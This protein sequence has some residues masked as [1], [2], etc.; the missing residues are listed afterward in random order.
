MKLWK[1]SQTE[2]EGYDTYSDAVVAAES[3]DDARKIHPGGY[4]DDS[5]FRDLVWCNPNFVKVEF[6]GEAKNGTQEGVICA[7]FHAG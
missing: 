4:E 1:I 3:E 2:H 6:L 7:S 5:Y